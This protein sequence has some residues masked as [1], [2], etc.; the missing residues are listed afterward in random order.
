MRPLLPILLLALCAPAYGDDDWVPVDS[1]QLDAA[2]GG[3]SAP[4]GPLVSLGIERTVTINGQLAVRTQF[5]IPDL[6]SMTPAQALLAQEALTS[7]GLV[8]NGPN[9]FAHAGL[10]AGALGGLVIQNSLSDQVIS[11]RTIIHASVNSLGL[12]SA[13]RLVSAIDLAVASAIPSN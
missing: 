12:A 7:G 3:F 4:G 1:A 10:P 13:L 9:N 6:A 2:R 8:Q 11:N 5:N